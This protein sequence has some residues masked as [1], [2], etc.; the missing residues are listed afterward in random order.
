[1][2]AYIYGHADVAIRNTEILSR[3]RTLE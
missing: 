3:E 2:Q 1:L